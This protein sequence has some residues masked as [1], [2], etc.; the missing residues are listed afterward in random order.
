MDSIESAPTR[1]DKRERTRASLL[2]A[3]LELTRERGFDGVT[4]QDIAERAGVTT[5]AIYGNF[6]NRDALFIALAERQW[7]PVRPVFR[8]GMSFAELMEAMATATI[9]S[10]SEREPGAVG[11]FTYRAYVLRTPEARV[12]FHDAMA[13]G[14]DAGAAWLTAVFD[15][16]DLPMAPNLLVRVINAL[17]EGLTFQRLMTPELIPDEAVYAA[18]GALAGGGAS[19]IRVPTRS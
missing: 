8:A 7:G 17:V 5:G 13:R 6:K 11:A 16:A 18:F 4:V 9:A 2:D 14:Y 12:R 10:F 3:A 1:G 15:E 19:G